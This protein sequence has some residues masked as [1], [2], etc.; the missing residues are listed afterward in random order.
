MK[1]YLQIFKSNLLIP[2]III[3]IVDAALCTIFDNNFL[4]NMIQHFSLN[5]SILTDQIIFSG[6]IEL[7]FIFL[8]L[9]DV[10]CLVKF[11]EKTITDSLISIVALLQNIAYSVLAILFLLFLAQNSLFINLNI[12]IK[13]YSVSV[14]IFNFFYLNFLNRYY[15]DYIDVFIF[16]YYNPI[17]N[18]L[19]TSENIPAPKNWFKYFF[20][21]KSK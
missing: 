2:T 15:K 13:I 7:F 6:L 4:K 5:I 10:F 14:T 16:G 12:W 8:G 21:L 11:F 1:K 9:Y 19:N 3:I 17:T 18:E 20:N